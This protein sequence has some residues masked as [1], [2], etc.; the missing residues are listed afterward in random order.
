MGQIAVFEHLGEPEALLEVVE[1]TAIGRV[2]VLDA[3]KPTPDAARL[4]D[5][6]KSVPGPVLILGV[7]RRTVGIVVAL[8][9]LRPQ[10][11]IATGD[12]EARLIVKRLLVLRWRRIGTRVKRALRILPRE[13][14]RADPGCRRR[15]RLVA[16]V[17]EREPK[18][19]VGLLAE[20]EAA[21][22]EVATVKT[23][24]WGKRKRNQ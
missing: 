8:N 13:N 11:V 12:P 2:H 6:L 4:V 18:I 16:A 3:R 19:R 9:D 20:R 24:H 17:N 10:H 22:D 5:S 15:V 1:A 21:E 7:S 23:S 14:F